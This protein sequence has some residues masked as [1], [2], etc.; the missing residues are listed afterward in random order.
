[1]VPLYIRIF[2]LSISSE[3]LDNNSLLNLIV[4]LPSLLLRRHLHKI[5]DKINRL[6]KLNAPIDRRHARIGECCLLA[7]RPIRIKGNVKVPYLLLEASPLLPLHVLSLG[8][9]YQLYLS[10]IQFPVYLSDNDRN[11]LKPSQF[12]S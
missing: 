2:L 3:A 12:R 10:E 7:Y 4:S 8:I 1:S 11:R 5:R 6:R 9:L